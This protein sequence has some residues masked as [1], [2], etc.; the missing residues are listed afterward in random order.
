[1]GAGGEDIR[2]HINDNTPEQYVEPILSNLFK[3]AGSQLEQISQETENCMS[4]IDELA[5]NCS[6]TLKIR[7]R[8][9]KDKTTYTISICTSKLIY[10]TGKA[11]IT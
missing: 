2:R 9:P 7:A 11:I 5:D 1:M 4:L 8:N 10:E 6:G 3:S